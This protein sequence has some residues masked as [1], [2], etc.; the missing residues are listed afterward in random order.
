MYGGVNELSSGVEGDDEEARTEASKRV[1]LRRFFKGRGHMTTF[2]PPRARRGH[3]LLCYCHLFIFSS[4]FESL[5][6][7]P[8][9]ASDWSARPFGDLD[10]SYATLLTW[11][12]LVS[13]H[14]PPF[15]LVM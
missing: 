5:V 7:S 11:L 14:I 8:S 10:V 12:A 15:A 2:S 3:V 9:F 1:E 6:P 4:F 13:Y